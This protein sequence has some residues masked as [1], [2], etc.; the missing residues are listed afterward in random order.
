MRHVEGLLQRDVGRHRRIGRSKLVSH[1]DLAATELQVQRQRD[2]QPRAAGCQRLSRSNAVSISPP[3][4]DVE[5]IRHVQAYLNL[6]STRA[7]L[8]VDPH[9][10]H[11]EITSYLVYQAFTANLDLQHQTYYYVANLLER[12][13]KCLIVS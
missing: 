9:L 13:I 7:T 5:R 3:E 10:K 8:G 11:Y 12:G 1:V 4:A 2:L 6:D